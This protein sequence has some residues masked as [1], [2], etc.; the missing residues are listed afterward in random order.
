MIKPKLQLESVAA[1]DNTSLTTHEIFEVHN[2]T[3]KEAIEL[4]RSLATASQM[5]P[6]SESDRSK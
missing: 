5:P 6:Q 3:L 2:I 4:V 1:S